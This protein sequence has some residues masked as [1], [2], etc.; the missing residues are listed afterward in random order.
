MDLQYTG[1]VM[2]FDRFFKFSQLLLRDEFVL[3]YSGY[4]SEDI[5]LAVGDT[6]RERLEDHARDGAQIRNVFSIFVE[7]MQNIIRYGVEGPQPGPEDGEKPSFGIVM[8]AENDGRLDV[9]AGNYVTSDEADQ[10]VERVNMLQSR[11]PEELR[12]MYRE[13]LKKTPDERSKGASLGL[14]EIARRST[15]PIV[16]EAMPADHGLRFFM[17]KATV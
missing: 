11:S 16:C 2:E 3:S 4:V 5:L 6:L 12:Q 14:I 13:R 7:L 17:I 9:I 10:L 1:G 8:V 15:L